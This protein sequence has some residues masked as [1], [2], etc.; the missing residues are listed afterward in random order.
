MLNSFRNRFLLN[1]GFF[2]FITIANCQEIVLPPTNIKSVQI[3][4]SEG[5]G[6]S[7]IIQKNG[8]IRLVFDDLEADEKDYYYLI[9]H[10]DHNWKKSDLL[11]TEFIRGYQKEKIR[12]YENSFNTLQFYTHY[13][14]NIPN[15]QTQLL[16]SGNYRI[17]ILNDDDD[18]IFSRYFIVYEP[19][20]TIGV[21]IHQSR[22]V[23]YIDT[24]Q[25]V[26]FSIN[27]SGL[28]INNPQEEI[29][30]LIIQNFDFSTQ[31]KGLKPQ[32]I[33][34]DQLL[35]KYDKETAFWGGN[36]YMNFDTK[37][38]LMSNMNVASVISGKNLYESILYTDIPRAY[39][40]Y[41]YYPDANGNFVIRNAKASNS[42]IEADYTWVHFSLNIPEFMDKQ[43]FVYGG[44]NDFQLTDENRMIFN[45]ITE[46]Y[47]VPILL[48]Q[49]FYNYTYTTLNSK[50]EINTSELNGSF[51][52]TENDYQVLIYYR[53][54]GSKYDRLIGFGKGN[55]KKLNQ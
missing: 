27:H 51:Y 16:I 46:N 38:L 22:D 2:L 28:T 10:C 20:T 9:E 15:E 37:E 40:P 31:I 1:F 13:S 5:D 21:S 12:T 42:E 26:Q 52:E 50:N 8:T 33:R 48:K 18:V 19:L 11:P 49:G 34:G 6:F 35:Y 14:L 32:F 54:F 3:T 30:P 23:G 29:F 44:F 17:S 45:S 36:E 4:S 55:S 53:K 39:D 43:V 24:Q 47:E 7:P 25:S 41:T